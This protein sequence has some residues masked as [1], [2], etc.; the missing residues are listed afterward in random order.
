MQF[1]ST[2]YNRHWRSIDGQYCIGRFV[3]YLHYCIFLLCSLMSASFL[4]PRTPEEQ[5]KAEA[6]RPFVRG[7]DIP[8]TEISI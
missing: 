6:E 5:A 2:L 4:K 3:P 7:A 8:E 1:R